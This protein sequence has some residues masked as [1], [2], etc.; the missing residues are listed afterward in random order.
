MP[1]RKSVKMN[2]AANT[3]RTT[4]RALAESVIRPQSDCAI[5]PLKTKKTNHDSTILNS[6]CSKLCFVQRQ[7]A[8][9]SFYDGCRNGRTSDAHDSI[10]AY[11]YKH[12]VRSS[13][14]AFDH[15][16]RDLLRGNRRIFRRVARRTNTPSLKTANANAQCQKQ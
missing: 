1:P 13:S 2:A 6:L 3:R 9:L 11:G 16:V 8:R 4:S 14:C 15:T 10:T 5:I 7:L 12:N